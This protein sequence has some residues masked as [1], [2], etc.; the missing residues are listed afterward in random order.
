VNPGWRRPTDVDDLVGL[1][2]ATVSTRAWVEQI[3]GMP[4]SVHVR[5]VGPQRADVAQAVAEVFTVLHRVDEVFSPWRADSHL[6]RVRRGELAERDADPWLGAVREL[7]RMAEQAVG[8]LFSTDLVGPDGTRGFDPTGL[9]KG[10][11]VDQ[12]AAA[13][14]AVPGIGFCINAG[15]DL[16][17]GRGPD[18]SA[19]DATW[20]VGIEDPAGGIAQVVTICDEALATSGTAIRGGHIIDPRTGDPVVSDLTS[21][22]VVGPELT[23]ADVW[24]TA[25]FIDPRALSN[26][27]RDPNSAQLQQNWRC[28]RVVGTTGGVGTTTPPQPP[29]PR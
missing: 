28:Y 9:V 22:T 20:R 16:I 8:G 3:M 24:A 4:V 18:A 27:V 21:L 14:R 26:A 23:W 12:A 19:V 29:V 7:A 25:C 17:C 11:G 1:P 2:S 10:W 15:G 6:L 5:S 13:L